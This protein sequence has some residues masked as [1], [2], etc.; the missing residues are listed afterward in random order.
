ME[1]RNG[2]KEV[3]QDLREGSNVEKKNKGENDTEQKKEK[4]RKGKKIPIW[5]RV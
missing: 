4:Y 2:G 5:I 1:G 3:S